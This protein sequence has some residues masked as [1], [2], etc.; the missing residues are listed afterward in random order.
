MA[1][2]SPH[3]QIVSTEFSASNGPRTAGGVFPV[4]NDIGDDT[5][6]NPYH[7]WTRII[8]ADTFA[9]QHGLGTITAATTA[10]TTATNYQGFDGIWFDDVV[11]TGTNGTYRKQAWDFKSDY[12]LRSPGFTVR[13]IRRNSTSRDMAL[14]G[15]SVGNGVTNEFRDVTDGTYSTQKIDAVDSR[16]TTPPCPA[17][18]VEAANAL[19]SG[20]DL[21]VVELGYNTTGD[22]R[23][24]HRR[25]DVGAGRRGVGRVAWVNMADI[26]ERCGRIVLLRSG[27]C[28]AAAGAGPLAEPVIA[29]WNAAR[30]Q[31]VRTVS[32]DLLRRCASHHD[33]PSPVRTVDAPGR[34]RIRP[35][36]GHLRATEQAVP[37]EPAH[38]TAGRR[39]QGRW[40]P[41]A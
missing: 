33:R 2:G 23:F 13:V 22:L 15:D 25:D 3:G 19:P 8:D 20:L 11:V 39:R 28:G 9:A 34:G 41:T 12:G 1:V 18:G 40:V 31:Q 24:R 4:V 32:V 17:S 7:R 36:R 35:G 10:P 16:T 30:P 37:A 6:P 27:Q 21:V 5:A 38:R 14:I 29:D 26:R